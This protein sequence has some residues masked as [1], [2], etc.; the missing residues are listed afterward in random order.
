MIGN[1]FTPMIESN[2]IAASPTIT[3]DA[4]SIRSP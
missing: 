2:G 1:A 3:V 4:V